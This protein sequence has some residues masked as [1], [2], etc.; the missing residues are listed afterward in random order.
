M[1]PHFLMTLKF[2]SSIYLCPGVQAHISSV[3]LSMPNSHLNPTCLTWNFWSLSS[4]NLFLLLSQAW[5][6]SSLSFQLLRP[7]PLESSIT[8]F[9]S[10]PCITNLLGSPVHSYS[11]I[12]S[13]SNNFLSLSLVTPW[14]KSSLFSICITIVSSLIGLSSFI[15]VPIAYP[16]YTSY[17]DTVKICHN[18]PFLCTHL[19]SVAPHFILRES[20]SHYSGSQGPCSGY[21]L[22]L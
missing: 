16:Q 1:T 18:I 13:E 12:F 22:P 20:L 11:K 2:V 14:S 9:F 3:S 10:S 5:L 7:K 8:I 17:T 21:H 6:I 4:S 19:M 15:L